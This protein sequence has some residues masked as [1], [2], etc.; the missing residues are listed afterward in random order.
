MQGN[1]EKQQCDF[2]DE[3]APGDQHL[4]ALKMHLRGN[5]MKRGQGDQGIQKRSLIKP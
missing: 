3:S 5:E 1:A 4:P 2:G